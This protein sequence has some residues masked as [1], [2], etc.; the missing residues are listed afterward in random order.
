MLKYNE[1]V[2]KPGQE[3]KFDYLWEGPFRI[4]NYKGV[5]TFKLK[6]MNGDP[7]WI[8]VNGFHLKPFH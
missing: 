6:D 3:A 1:R 4:L 5:N 7:L 8:L 2:A